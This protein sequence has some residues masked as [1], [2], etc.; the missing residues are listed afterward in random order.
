[1]MF[2]LDEEDESNYTDTFKSSGKGKLVDGK[3]AYIK[4]IR[5]SDDDEDYDEEDLDP[6]NSYGRQR[7]F[8]EFEDEGIIYH[9][10]NKEEEKT[11]KK[12]D[13]QIKVQIPTS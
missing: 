12:V 8:S 13:I 5:E 6:D 9:K 4:K 7:N 1:M 11:K 3:I 2:T 10:I